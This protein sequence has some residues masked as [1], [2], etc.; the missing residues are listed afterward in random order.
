MHTVQTLSL[1]ARY[2]RPLDT[3]V[4]STFVFRPYS[5]MQWEFLVPTIPD[6]IRHIER[7]PV[8]QDY[9]VHYLFHGQ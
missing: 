4:L 8:W 5:D 9:G 7:G 6:D 2:L 1:C 3:D